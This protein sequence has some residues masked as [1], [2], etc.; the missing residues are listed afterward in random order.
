MESLLLCGALRLALCC[1]PSVSLCGEPQPIGAD[2]PSLLCGA[3]SIML[4]GELQPLGA[5]LPFLIRG[6]EAPSAKG[7]LNPGDDAQHGVVH[8][9]AGDTLALDGPWRL[10]VYLV[11]EVDGRGGA[12]VGWHAWKR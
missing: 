7:L 1:G 5:E 4:C 11:E 9:V 6:A 3:P 2:A 8:R 10:L 12:S